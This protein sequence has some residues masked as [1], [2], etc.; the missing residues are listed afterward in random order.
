MTRHQQYIDYLCNNFFMQQ[1]G[2]YR[3]IRDLVNASEFEDGLIRKQN[4]PLPDCWRFNDPSHENLY[5]QFE[6][7]EVVDC[8]DLS[9]SKLMFLYWLKD[10]VEGIKLSD[11]KFLDIVFYRHQVSDRSCH[12]FDPYRMDYG[13]LMGLK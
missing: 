13:W 9:R 11:N 5:H 2:I 8:N 6:W 4:K 10:W 7:H 1:T 3:H 12:E